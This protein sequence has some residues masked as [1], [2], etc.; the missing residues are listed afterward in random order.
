[1]Q[2]DI[3][4]A[5]KWLGGS[6]VAACCVCVVGFH[7]AVTGWT[8]HIQKVGADTPPVPAD[9]PSHLTPERI[10]GGIMLAPPAPAVGRCDVAIVAPVNVVLPADP[11]A[12]L[13]PPS[14]PPVGSPPPTGRDLRRGDCPPVTPPLCSGPAPPSPVA[15]GKPFPYK[16]GMGSVYMG[17]GIG[18]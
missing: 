7:P 5:A 4:K 8:T 9:V 3:V 12:I 13:A 14:V 10:H 11:L 17:W 15:P 16:P 1:M 2:G 6:I 18:S